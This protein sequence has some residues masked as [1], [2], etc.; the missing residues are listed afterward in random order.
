[1]RCNNVSL[2]TDAGDG[3]PDSFTTSVGALGILQ[4]NLFGSLPPDFTS[5]DFDDGLSS[6][7]DIGP[8]ATLGSP[9]LED[10]STLVAQTESF[11]TQAGDSICI[12]GSS[13][14]PTGS[15]DHDC[16]RE[17]YDIL[18]SLPFH[19]F[20]NAHSISQ[21]PPGS[22]STTT[23]TADRVPLDHA[24]HL[25][26][27]A[28]ERLSRLL[29]C[30][31]ARSPHLTMLYASII[32]RVL[33]WYQ[34]AAGCTQSA[35]WSS[36]SMTLNA[37]S[38]H[39]SVIGSTLNSGSGIDESS[40]WP[41]TAAATF[42]TDGTEGALTLT[43][44]TELTVAPAKMAI[45][46][47][48]VDDLRVQTALKIQLISGEMRRAGRLI[49]LFSSYNSGGKYL[50]NEYTSGGVESLYQGLDSWLRGEHSRIANTMRLKLR[51]LNT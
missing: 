1:M 38:H 43:R 27:E 4:S 10:N 14:T 46:T 44:T 41:S 36:A 20:D 17:A 12:D 15:K 5:P 39:P 13:L 48:N 18:G 45:G 37:T 32:S 22:A 21:S 8:V 23:S 49:D 40:T 47:F 33:N 28:S 19:S 6:S 11:Q 25:H 9:E 30:I 51:E 3:Y 29:T 42:G 2:A 50:T 7:M 24:L 16:F 31:C 34:Q 35:S 26:R